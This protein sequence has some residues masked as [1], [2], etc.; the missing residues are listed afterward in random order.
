MASNEPR[1]RNFDLVPDPRITI[2]ARGMSW[3]HLRGLKHDRTRSRAQKVREN[4]CIE[5]GIQTCMPVHTSCSI[6]AHR[7]ISSNS[8]GWCQTNGNP[9][10]FTAERRLQTA[11]SRRHSARAAARFCLKFGSGVEAALLVEVVVDGGVDGGEL[12]QT[13]H[14]PE[15]Q[16][17]PL[18]SSEWQVRILRPVVEPAAGLLPVGARRSPS[19]RHRRTAACRSR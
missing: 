19:A 11:Q 9:S 6:P 15:A 12:L 3:P 5:G 10:Q 14:P 1:A 17:R 2:P 7:I 13:S 4:P 18:P 16:H 8:C